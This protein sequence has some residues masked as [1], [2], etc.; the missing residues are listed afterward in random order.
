MAGRL[1]RVGDHQDRLSLGVDVAKQPQQLVGGLGVQSTGGLVGQDEAGV[2]DESPGHG[3][4]LLLAAG[5]LIGVLFQQVGDAQLSRQ[6]HQALLHLAGLLTR[7]HQGQV[8][9]VLQGEGVQQVEVL[10]HKAQVVPAEGRH[11]RLPDFTQLLAVQ[12]HQA[13]GGLIQR[14]Q[15]IQKGGLAGARLSHDGHILPF[16]HMEGDIFQRLHLGAAKAGGV[17]LL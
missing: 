14:R 4:P 12:L 7:E 16:L 6:R 11:L 1:H 13:P 17:D 15:D 10:E 5:H 3:C 9:V 2:G 8:D